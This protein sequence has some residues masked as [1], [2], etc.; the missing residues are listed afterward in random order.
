V[1]DQDVVREPIDE[2]QT[3]EDDLVTDVGFLF[4]S[5]TG[6]TLLRIERAVVK[7]ERVEVLY[8]AAAVTQRVVLEL[9]SGVQLVLT[10]ICLDYTF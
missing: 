10:D 9:A 6:W 2:V 5:Q 3:A 4:G 1:C 8:V 7:E